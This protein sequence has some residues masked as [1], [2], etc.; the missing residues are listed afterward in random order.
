MTIRGQLVIADPGTWTYLN[1]DGARDRFR[2]AA[3]HAVPTVDEQG[4][5]EPGAAFSWVRSARVIAR[6]D[7]LSAELDVVAFSQDGFR[8]LQDPVAHRRALVRARC[9]YWLIVDS[10]RSARSHNV[11]ISYPL[12]SGLRAMAER[13]CAIIANARGELARFVTA[14]PEGR[15]RVADAWTSNAYGR[16]EPAARLIQKMSFSG[17]LLVATLV[18]PPETAIALSSISGKDGSTQLVI[19]RAPGMRDVFCFGEQS[20]SFVDSDGRRIEWT[21]PPL[22]VAASRSELS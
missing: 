14:D 19:E 4:S 16:R 10:F 11:A 20:C 18:Q 21:W 22:A 7:H 8:H 2:E 12:A 17:N 1:G 9:D 13:N 15:W 3:A 5:S 6:T